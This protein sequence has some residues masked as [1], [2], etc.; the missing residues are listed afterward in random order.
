MTTLSRAERRNVVERFYRQVSE[1]TNID[2]AW[3]REKIES[4][5]PELHDEPPP[6]QCDA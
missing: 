3:M 4:S 2:P 6:K 5:A 1:D